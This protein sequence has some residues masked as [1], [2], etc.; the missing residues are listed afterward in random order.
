MWIEIIA[1]IAV[2][3][4]VLLVFG[5]GVLV[6]YGTKSRDDT[7]LEVYDD[8]IK[9]RLKSGKMI[10]KDLIDQYRRLKK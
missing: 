5:L 9:E 10:D 1:A 7:L 3:L 8:I 4:F 6:G 2:I